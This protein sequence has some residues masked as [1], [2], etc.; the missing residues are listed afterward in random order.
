LPNVLVIAGPNGAGKS[1]AAPRLIGRRLGIAEFVNADVIAA[2]LSA[3]APESVALEAG[4]AMLARLR[5]LASAGKDFAFETTLASRSF[6][7][8]LA[9]LRRENHYRFHLAFLWLPNAEMAVGRVAGRIRGGGH[10]VPPDDIRRR[11]QRG[12]GNFFSLYTPIAD[13]WEMHDNASPPA[14]LIAA[15]E[16]SS[17]IRFGDRVLWEMIQDRMKAKEQESE[18][19]AGP[20]PRLMGVPISEVMEIFTLAGREAMARHKALGLP[21]VVWRDG[22]VVEIPPEDIQI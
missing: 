7:P 6:A 16:G 15:R 20:E 12:L 3:F 11:Y 8:W 10:A 21:V 5:Q 22:K 4:R 2:G 13:S 1:S 19:G 18:Y 9:R 14:R 17:P